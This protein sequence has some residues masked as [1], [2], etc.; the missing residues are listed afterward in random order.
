M[1]KIK[2][3]LNRMLAPY[4]IILIGDFDMQVIYSWSEHDAIDWAA[5]ALRSDTVMIMHNGSFLTMRNPVTE[6]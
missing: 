3:F 6:A 5:Y 4:Q 1:K 2:D